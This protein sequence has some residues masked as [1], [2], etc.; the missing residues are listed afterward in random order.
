MCEEYLKE[1]ISELEE[2]NTNLPDGLTTIEYAA[3]IEYSLYS[4][5]LNKYL[6]SGDGT[7]KEFECWSR[8]I[9]QSIY[10]LPKY[11]HNTDSLFRGV[12][13]PKKIF[14]DIMQTMKYV[15]KGF[16]STSQE[17]ERAEHFMIMDMES[18]QDWII[19]V[20]E[21]TQSDVGINL[22]KYTGKK[23]LDGVEIL[24]PRGVQFKVVE[25]E[26]DKKEF[27]NGTREM[28]RIRMHQINSNS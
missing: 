12:Q 20:F 7:Q 25:V 14:N 21:V 28:F 18:E 8:L 6:R 11:S 27:V 9:D 19:G 23:Q 10:K 3:L 13:L 26:F 4:D 17:L 16:F 15:E 1:R 2:S 22:S 5:D 24:F